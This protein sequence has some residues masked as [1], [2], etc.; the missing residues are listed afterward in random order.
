MSVETET[1]S[2]RRIINQIIDET[3][4]NDP[5][6][7]ASKAASMIPP[8]QREQVLATLLISEARNLLGKHRN[9]AITNVVEHRNAPTPMAPV[10][11][12]VAPVTPI[13]ARPAVQEPRTHTP[14]RSPKVTGI[15]DWWAETL[16]ASV[17]VGDSK[18]MALGE[19]TATELLFME[20]E[21]RKLAERENSKAKMYFRLR[22]LLDEYGV[23]TV[24]QLPENA[25]RQAMS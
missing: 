11:K 17:H 3:S 12:P 4:L 8:E 7:I 1:F 21:R 10:L 20:S 23:K 19:C 22:L 15:R 16:R 24:A 5:R 18:W 25:A 2:A 9:T 13:S 14:R 6:E